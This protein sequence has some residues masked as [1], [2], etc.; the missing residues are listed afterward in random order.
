MSSG[1]HHCAQRWD[2]NEETHYVG[3][4]S[5]FLVFDQNSSNFKQLNAVIDTVPDGDGCCE[6]Y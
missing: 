1:T 3:A 6:W 2:S 4:I 5:D